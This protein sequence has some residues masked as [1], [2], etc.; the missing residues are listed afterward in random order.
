[1]NLGPAPCSAPGFILPIADYGHTDGRCSI[2]GGYVYRGR[3]ASLPYG[4]YIYGDYCSGEIFMLKDG[5]Q[6]VLLKTTMNISSF[7]EDEAGEIYVVDLN[8]S[9]FRI[10][11]P[12][13]LTAASR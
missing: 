13:A 11:N 6:T 8:G 7:G 2:T 5:V 10:T 4:A 1:M 12:D 9:V 3:Q